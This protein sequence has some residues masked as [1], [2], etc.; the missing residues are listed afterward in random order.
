LLCNGNINFCSSGEQ[1]KVVYRYDVHGHVTEI[2][3]D[4]VMTKMFRDSQSGELNFIATNDCTLRYHRNGPLVQ[5]HVITSTKNG[6][7]LATFDYSH[8]INLRL[9]SLEVRETH[10]TWKIFAITLEFIIFTAR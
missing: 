9:N 2:L 5:R 1:R 4:S 7:L 6:G 3:H 8:D 10:G